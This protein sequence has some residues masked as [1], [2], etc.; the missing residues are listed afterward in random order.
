MFS[1]RSEN[2]GSVITVK[3]YISADIEGIVGTTNWREGSRG[4]D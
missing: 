2:K 4:S 1:L 3:V